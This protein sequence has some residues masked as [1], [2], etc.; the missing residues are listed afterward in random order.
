MERLRNREREGQKERLT[1]VC[2]DDPLF[3]VALQVY[4]ALPQLCINLL[5]ESRRYFSRFCKLD[6]KISPT[7][8]TH[9]ERA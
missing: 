9:R 4:F 5:Q 3:Q 1:E 8:C 2:A 7:E 6:F